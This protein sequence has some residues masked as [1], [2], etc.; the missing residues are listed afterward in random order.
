MVKAFTQSKKEVI[1]QN[2]LQKGKDLF[3]KYGLKKTSVDDL[4]KATGIAKGSFYKFFDSKESLF[5]AI[6]EES[7][8]SMQK[9][10]LQK[11]ET[12]TDP[13]E[14]LRTFF[15]DTFLL[16]EEDPLLRMVFQKDEME[17]LSSFMAS[18][19]FL[20]HYK[21]DITFMHSLIKNWQ[22][23]GIIRPLDIEVVT[24]LITS[25]YYILLQEIT[26]GNEMFT[27][28]K[29]MMIECLVNYLSGENKN[30]ANQSKR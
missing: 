29:E 11:L 15:T 12:I 9:N 21:Q 26:L 3:I 18:E 20:E 30:E 13:T 8:A 5:M 25:N 4:V 19:Q 7:E 6:H 23:E 27:R 1:R 28:V 16:L 17:N 14:K 22:D 2:L 24:H 10:M